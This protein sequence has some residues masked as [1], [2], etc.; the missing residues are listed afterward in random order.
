MVLSYSLEYIDIHSYINVSER[1]CSFIN[2]THI[3]P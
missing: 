2:D 3:L 1:D